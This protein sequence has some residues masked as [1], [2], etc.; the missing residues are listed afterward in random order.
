MFDFFHSVKTFNGEYLDSSSRADT[1][2]AIV[3]KYYEF[4]LHFWPLW[5]N[6]RMTEDQLIWTKTIVMHFKS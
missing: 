3:S 4:T 5:R 1:K 2:S 6:E